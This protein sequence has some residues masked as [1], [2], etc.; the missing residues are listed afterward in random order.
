M[1][2]LDN[3]QEVPSGRELFGLVFRHCFFQCLKHN[4]Y[5][6]SIYGKELMSAVINLPA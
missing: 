5:A 1:D 4:R 3:R 2:R 6:K